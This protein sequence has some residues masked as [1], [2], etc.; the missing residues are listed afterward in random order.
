VLTPLTQ[1]RIDTLGEAPEQAMKIE[2]MEGYPRNLRIT[3]PQ[4]EAN[5]D[6]L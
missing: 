4:E 1:Q 6:Q 2:A 3:R 5:I